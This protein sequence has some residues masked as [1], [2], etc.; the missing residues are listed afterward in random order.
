MSSG[1]HHALLQFYEQIEAEG[2][3]SP[4]TH[5][6]RLLRVDQIV[7]EYCGEWLALEEDLRQKYGRGFFPQGSPG[8][9][10]CGSHHL[11]FVGPPVR[12]E[13]LERSVERQRSSSSGRSVSPL[14]APTSYLSELQRQWPKRSPNLLSDRID[15]RNGTSSPSPQGASAPSPRSSWATVEKTVNFEEDDEEEEER[16]HQ[17]LSMNDGRSSHPSPLN[18]PT[19]RTEVTRSSQRLPIVNAPPALV[20]RL[21]LERPI[22]SP[23]P[24]PFD[25]SQAIVHEFDESTLGSER[26]SGNGPGLLPQRSRAQLLAEQSILDDMNGGRSRKKDRASTYPPPD[27]PKLRPQRV[28][29]PAD[30]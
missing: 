11:K 15:V 20:S 16:S 30:G 13:S 10:T 3:L 28:D 18:Q 5:Q 23:R 22:P 2:L 9:G 8:C 25:P 7:E 17:Q 21:Q 26:G 14:Q 1:I 6:Q 12:E 24:E 4:M 27:G 29:G 19:P